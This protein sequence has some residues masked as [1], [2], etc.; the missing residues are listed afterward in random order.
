MN[1]KIKYFLFG[2]IVGIVLI[3][4]PSWVGPWGSFTEIIYKYIEKIMP[5]ISGSFFGQFIIVYLLSLI[6]FFI[7]Q[8]TIRLWL[9]ATIPQNWR[10]NFI[11]YSMGFVIIFALFMTMIMIAVSR[12]QIL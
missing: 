12:F 3:L 5:G 8:L 2:L 1:I 11:F 4:M 6:L 9:N 10:M 7:N